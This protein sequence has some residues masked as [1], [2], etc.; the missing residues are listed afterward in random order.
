MMIMRSVLFV[1][2]DCEDLLS[3]TPPQSVK[4]QRYI[5]H[6]ETEGITRVKMYMVITTAYLIFWA[7]LFLVSGN[8]VHPVQNYKFRQMLINEYCENFREI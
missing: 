6:L 8:T 7:P 2:Q 1:C 4:I 3:I 5:E